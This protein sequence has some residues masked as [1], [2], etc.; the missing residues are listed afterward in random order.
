[1]SAGTLA[2]VAGTVMDSG[3][4][5]VMAAVTHG[6]FV[7]GAME[8]IDESPLHRVFVTDSVENHPIPLSPR[9]RVVSV[10]ALFAEAIRRIH[11]RESISVL[12]QVPGSRG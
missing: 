7:P 3:A 6:V 9:V 5:S 2:E 10:S 1:M 8:R 11:R 12:F 4:R